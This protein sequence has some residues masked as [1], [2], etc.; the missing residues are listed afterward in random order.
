MQINATKSCCIRI[1]RNHSHTPCNLHTLLNLDIQWFDQI[2][3]LGVYIISRNDFCCQI[4]HAKSSFYK[5]FNYIY[6][7][8]GNTAS[9]ETLV[10]LIKTKCI[11]RLVYGLECLTLNVSQIRSLDFALRSAFMK[12]FK[13]KELDIIIDCMSFFNVKD[14]TSLL[15]ISKDKLFH[16][17]RSGVNRVNLIDSVIV[18]LLQ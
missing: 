14:I 15:A 8:I 12:I 1:G 4:D 11:P 13:T 16:R 10:H 17:L 6:G 3:Y 18:R 9:E 5:C 7:K 2:R